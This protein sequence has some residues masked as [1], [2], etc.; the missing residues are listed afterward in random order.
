MGSPAGSVRLSAVLGALLPLLG[1]APGAAAQVLVINAR[2]P[3]AGAYPQGAVIPSTRSIS[4]KA[5]DQLEVLDASGSHVLTGPETISAGLV[6][7]GTKAALQDIFRRANASR[8][9]IAA[10]RGFSLQ[11]EAKPASPP[12]SQP[13]WRLDV[14]AWQQAEPMDGHNFC[15]T[16]GQTAQLT[17]ASGAAEGKLVIY[18]EATHAT[19]TVIWPAGARTLAWPA[20]LPTADGSV[21]DLNLDDQG[22]TS[23]RWRALPTAAASVTD[24]AASLLAD[25]CYDQLE[26][27]QAQFAAN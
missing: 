26:T 24:L 4:L 11:D 14:A 18:Q 12:D 23:V 8:P 1:L 21:Y 15:L 7:A 22:A 20:D 17:R 16:P 13:L 9:G 27:L 2:G 6:G 25:S 10:V 5:G 3:S 19:R